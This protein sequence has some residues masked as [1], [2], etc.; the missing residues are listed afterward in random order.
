MSLSTRS[1]LVQRLQDLGEFQ[2]RLEDTS[3]TQ[4]KRKQALKESLPADFVE[5]RKDELQSKWYVHTLMLLGVVIVPPYIVGEFVWFAPQ[6]LSEVIA[7]PSGL[8]IAMV[9]L[10]AVVFFGGG[11]Y[12]L[13]ELANYHRRLEIYTVLHEL[14]QASAD[15]ELTESSESSASAHVHE[16]ASASVAS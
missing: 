7:E 5:E 6:T 8:F 1:L 15:A 2:E 4:Y 10:A 14:D 13:R 9:A 16:S 12:R 11:F 3:M